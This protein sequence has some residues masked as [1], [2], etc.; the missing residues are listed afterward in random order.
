[1]TMYIDSMQRKLG[2][3]VIYSSAILTYTHCN[4]AASQAMP[5][6]RSWIQDQIT[7]MSLLQIGFCSYYNGKARCLLQ[8]WS[9]GS[10]QGEMGKEFAFTVKLCKVKR[11]VK[12]DLS[13]SKSTSSTIQI[14][15]DRRSRR[16]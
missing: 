2:W 12:L 7:V 1:M 3:A 16:L 6:V 14:N 13:R 9:N 11:L 10:L 15:T 5:R 8:A 4:G